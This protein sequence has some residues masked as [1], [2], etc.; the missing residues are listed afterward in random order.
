MPCVVVNFMSA[1]LGHGNKFLSNI[2]LDA[3]V[4]TFLIAL[5]DVAHWVGHHPTDQKKGHLFH[6]SQSTCL[7]FGPGP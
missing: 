7:G 6:S 4:K 1:W 2:S 3:V 5:T